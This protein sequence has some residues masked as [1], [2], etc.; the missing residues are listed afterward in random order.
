MVNTKVEC[1][2][3][4][5]G[6][7]VRMTRGSTPGRTPSSPVFSTLS[8]VTALLRTVGLTKAYPGVVALDE[9]TVD[10][11]PGT[12]GLVGANGAGKTTL[13]R[14]MLGL[15]PP[16]AGTIE[17]AGVDV[18][19]NPVAVR[20]RLGF[21]PEHDCLPT[22]QSAADVVAT[23]G[24]L[25]GLPPRAARQRASDVLDL[26][27]LDEARFRP[28]EGFSTG[29]RQRTKLAQAIVGD[30]SVVLLDEP[31]AGLDPA[32]REEMLA[33]IQRLG[34]FGISIVLATHLLDDV[35]QV[36]DQVVMLD[37]GRLVTA[38]RTDTLVETTG[39]VSIDAGGRTDALLTALRSTDLASET[40]L[41]GTVSVT[42]RDDD[43]LDR[44]V[45]AIAAAGLPLHRLS[46]RNRSLDDVFLDRATR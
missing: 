44:I 37:G 15:T 1:I 4:N 7:T 26:V 29:M 42:V 33:L 39:T 27:G 20:T 9:L 24:E 22:D 21:M 18:A 35:Q 14:I 30:P 45:A 46:P 34:G 28:V 32:G 6:L 25:G 5:F 2:T 36:C 38:G 31:T 19:A 10:I 40:A 43:D 16:D 13:F 11:G 12:V 3:R 41:D 8:A 23:L 17:V